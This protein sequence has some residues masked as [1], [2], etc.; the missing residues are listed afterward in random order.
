M[1]KSASR[2][3]EILKIVSTSRE[4]L[5]H[6]EI[7]QA[8]GIPKG[9][10]TFLLA[11]LTSEEFLVIEN[12]GR[13]KIGPQILFLANRYLASLDIINFSEPILKELVAKTNESSALAVPKG[14]DVVVVA[15]QN[16]FQQLKL[17]FDIGVF[18][19]L[20]ATAMG[21]VILA[22]L[23]DEK[24]KHYLSTVKLVPITQNTIVDPQRLLK[25][26]KKIRENSI[27]YSLEEQFEG[28][29]ALAAPVFNNKGEVT[30]SLT[31]QIPTVRFTPEK[32]QLLK[33][34]L[35]EAS[36]NLSNKLGFIY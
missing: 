3:M 16:A 20:Y 7:S 18:F 33:S 12:D 30:A 6:S 11:D 9:S 21:K 5:K 24:L 28:R 26:L 10:L 35:L 2:V 34:A 4:G 19:P 8:L 13:Y 27:A 14:K 17:E 25:E 32:E 22:Y 23:T 29:I 15:K 1:V 36:K 31:Q